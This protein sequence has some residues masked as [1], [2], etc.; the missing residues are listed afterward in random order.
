MPDNHDGKIV[1]GVTLHAVGRAP[2]RR[3]RFL[4]TRQEVFAKAR[5]IDADLYHIHDPELLQYVRNHRAV[6]GK[7]VIYDV[8]EDYPAAILSK[9]WLPK[10]CRPLVSKMFDIYERKI[11]MKIDGLIVAWPKIMKRFGRHPQRVLINNYPY[12]DEL[13]LV[14]GAISKRRLGCFVYVGVLSPERGILEMVK[15]V[16]KSGNKYRLLLGGQWSSEHYEKECRAEYGWIACEYKGYLGR[17]DIR[18]LF[19]FAQAGLIAFF[20]EPNHLYSMPNKIFEYMSAGLPVIASDLPMQRSIVGETG[21]GLVADAQSPDAIYEKMRWIYEHPDAA[22]AMGHAGRQAIEEKFNWEN[23][24][25]KLRSFY[26]EVMRA[27]LP[28]GNRYSGR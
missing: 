16:G 9:S 13:Q 26:Q 1:D 5:I 2:N 14:Q 21:C 25:I 6:T 8:H 23:E 18:D 28:H 17:K 20:P 10:L 24:A 4:R 12:R 7:P 27:R 22:E 15:A 11:I 19:S 3:E